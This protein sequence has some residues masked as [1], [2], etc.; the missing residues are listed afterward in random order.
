MYLKRLE[1][2]GFKS[3][4]TKTDILFNQ[5]ITAIVGPNGSGKSNISDA[6]RWVLGEQSIKSLRGDKLEDVIFAGTDTKKPMNYC[7]VELTI[8]NS[9][10]QLNLEFSE[11][12]IKRRAYRSGESS[13]FLNNKACRLK[14]IKEILLDT[15][16]G[17]DGYSIIEQG[18]VDEILS[19][20][21]VNR[22]KVFDEACGI[23]KFR[24]KKDEANR[25]LK[26]TKENLERID[27]IYIEIENQLKPLESQQKKATKYLDLSQKLKDIEVNNFLNEIDKIEIELKEIEKSS[28]TLKQESEKMENDKL[29]IENEFTKTNNEIETLNSNIDKIQAFIDTIRD[30]LSEKD[31]QISLIKEKIKNC[32]KDIDRS[33][34]DVEKIKINIT[35]NEKEIV[36][37]KDKKSLTDNTIKEIESEIDKKSLENKEIKDKMQNLTN[38]IEILK[39]EIIN[40]LGKKQD[41]SNKKS[42]LQANVENISSRK[43]SIDSYLKDIYSDLQDKNNHKINISNLIKESNQKLYDKQNQEKEISE[44]IRSSYTKKDQ[45]EKEIISI[46]YKLTDLKSKLNVYTE[47]E[48]HYEGFNR[49]VKEVLKNKSLTGI[50]GALGQLIEVPKEY[51]KAIEAALG[52]YM[53][54]IITVDENS[55]KIAINYL[56][57]NNLGRVTFLPSNII[58]SSRVDE[59]SINTK[60]SFIGIA[61]DLIKYDNKYKNI[62][63]NVLG[64][65]LIIDNMDKAILFARE[66]NHRYKIVTLDGEILNPGGSMT[67]GSLKT[68]G[69]ILSRKRLINEYSQNIEDINNKVENLEKDRTIVIKKIEEFKI[70][71]NNV[72][73]EIKILDKKTIIENSNLDRII[74]DIKTLEINSQK[75]GSEKN[76][77]DENLEY[78]KSKSETIDKEIVEI[79]NKHNENKETIEKLS[80]E[81]KDIEQKYLKEQESYNQSNLNLVK[82]RQIQDA[83]NKD[84]NRITHEIKQLELKYKEVIEDIKNKEIENQELNSNIVIEQSEKTNLE[85]QLSSNRKKLDK[86]QVD[87][88]ELRTKVDET[89]K[90]IKNIDRKYMDIKE[91]IF[92]INSKTERLK[93]SQDDYINKLFEKYEMTV[94]EALEIRNKEIIIDKRE[95]ENIKR[96]IRNLG[97][98][99]IDSIKEY[100]EV[101]ERYDFYSEQKLDLEQSM[102]VIESLISEVELNMKIE[103][104]T[105]FKQINDNFK[106]VYKRLFGGGF[107]ELC[108]V[109]PENI[110]ESDI[111]ITAQPPGKKMKNLSLLSGGEKALT[112]ISILFSILLAKP[113]P[114]CILDE[115]EAPLDDANIF[116]FGEFLKELAK[117]TQFIS[118]T[119]RRGTMEAADYIYGVTMQEKAISKVLSLKLEEA[120]KITDVI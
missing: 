91:S 19:N 71:Q 68:S 23:S 85:N 61:S 107:G 57:R 90:L 112:A 103:F 46:N 64:R 24:Y 119:H 67:G 52:A 50:I 31:S 97:N 75:F 26:N 62:F 108:I 33:N 94:V 4:P 59:R 2:K 92:K 6:V 78:T 56:K 77:L 86:K 22:R 5:G 8:D 20:N 38:D 30:V 16:I 116:R 87:R 60:T 80:K 11:I 101:K 109:D 48:N 55:A 99:N 45:I 84:I 27:D 3:F 115:I 28:N 15:G 117:D 95:L 104:E 65:T 93:S 113:T 110:L 7:E 9:D 44:N 49:G 12:T 96:E 105:N 114:F 39:D 83:L 100:E 17:K 106:Y 13:F 102:E 81:Y 14:D 74:N 1:I 88:N 73:E 120:K 118:V 111:E 25:N 41:A 98:V 35:N 29:N 69:N 37:L 18:K 66:N 53:Q 34:H 63:E 58:K 43:E 21:P 70:L 89:N 82:D 72:V 47:M 51:E 76:G 32:I 54:N 79:E 10:N 36:L 40:L 42:T